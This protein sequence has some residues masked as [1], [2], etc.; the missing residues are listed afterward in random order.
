MLPFGAAV[1]D[2]GWLIEFSAVVR[3]I[4][5]AGVVAHLA[6]PASVHEFPVGALCADMRFL[7]AAPVLAVIVCMPA[8]ASLG[9]SDVV[10]YLLS[11]S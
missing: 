5:A 1:A 7:A 11:D 4:V 9:N 10:F 8:A 3:F 6:G 2:I